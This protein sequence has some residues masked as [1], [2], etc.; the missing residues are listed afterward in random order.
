MDNRKSLIAR[1]IAGYCTKQCN[2][3][4]RSL[5]GTVL[6]CDESYNRFGVPNRDHY[7][8]KVICTLCGFETTANV[9]KDRVTL[10][11]KKEF[12]DGPETN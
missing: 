1:E 9:H 11:P 3:V 5:D 4:F 8:F 12:S 6:W 10:D 2:F 7:S